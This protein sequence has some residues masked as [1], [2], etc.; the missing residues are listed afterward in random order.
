MNNLPMNNNVPQ[1]ATKSAQTAL[2]ANPVSTSKALNVAKPAA[3]TPVPGKTFGDV[4]AH[5]VSEAKATEAVSQSPK[6]TEQKTTD[7]S[8]KKADGGVLQPKNVTANSVEKTD[9]DASQPQKVSDNSAE[10]TDEDVSQP[11]KITTKSAEEIFTSIK[12]KK[13]DGS[14]LTSDATASTPPDMLATLIPL[15]AATAQSTAIPQEA[16]LAQGTTGAAKDSM[17]A[18]Q[19]IP[20]ASAGAGAVNSAQARSTP[21]VEAK[22]DTAFSNMMETITS[23]TTAKLSDND[24][25]G[26]ALAAA[27]Q[28][29]AN[30]QAAMQAAIAS[31]AAASVMPAQATIN[32]PV[33]H[34]KWGDE[35]NQKI[36]WLTSQ[37]EQTAELHLN[38]PQLGPMDVVLKV[39][40]DQATALF[41]SPHAAVREAVEQ[42]LPRLREMLADSGIMLGNATVSDQAPRGRQDDHE[43]KSSSR[44]GI[45]GVADTATASHQSVR[46]SPISR[47][48]GIVDTFA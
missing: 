41:T 44:S 42:A 15:N 7:K 16:A 35:F 6:V 19:V 2:T 11:K 48:N 28:A 5:R 47:H 29:S 30:A 13:A 4:L 17:G 26:A 23:A 9:T 18:E 31:P 10:A 45:G 14:A 25:K 38:P 39:S 12:A 33:S 27:P 46:V 40:G 20:A 34:E 43:H 22:K 36:T 24:E 37:K 8:A 1:T 3:D 32:T 21:P